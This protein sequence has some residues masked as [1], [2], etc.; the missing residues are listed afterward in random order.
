MMTTYHSKLMLA[1]ALLLTAS[2]ASDTDAMQCKVG[3]K[4]A[5][6]DLSELGKQTMG[7]TVQDRAQ[8]SQQSYI[9]TFGI[10]RSVAAPANCL[11]TDGSSRV[12]YATAPAWQT[13]ADQSTSTTTDRNSL[14]CKYLGSPDNS[15]HSWSPIDELDPAK[16]VKL[17]YNGGQ[18]CSNGQQRK[19]ALNMKCA[20]R[21]VE[22]IEQK[23]IDESAHCEY[24]IEIESEYAC[25]TECGLAA[26]GAICGGHGLC[27]F[28]TTTETSKC[29]CNTGRTGAHCTDTIEEASD[30]IGAV[31]GLLVF[32]VIALLGLG[33]LLVMMWRHMQGR[34]LGSMYSALHADGSAAGTATRDSWGDNASSDILRVELDEPFGDIEFEQQITL[35]VEHVAEPYP[36]YADKSQL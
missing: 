6:Y 8:V 21:T 10:C 18:H 9:Y 31:I 1:S 28:D 16:G 17:T 32:I 7:F 2:L 13:R 15:D 33:A 19:F 3:L 27:G 26:T 36:M 35:G 4:G 29:F 34:S 14:T 11:N 5:T 30:G 24:E 22:T 23:V 20:P 25:P 12:R